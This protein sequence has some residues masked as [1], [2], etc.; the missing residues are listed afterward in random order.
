MCERNFLL[1]LHGQYIE[2]NGSK[3][4]RYPFGGGSQMV[5][6]SRGSVLVARLVCRVVGSKS[7][8]NEDRSRRGVEA[9]KICRGLKPSRG[10]VGE[11]RRGPAWVSS[12]LLGSRS[13]LLGPPQIA[14]CCFK[15]GRKSKTGRTTFC[16][17]R[18]SYRVD[19][20]RSKY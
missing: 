9:C 20:S 2:Q 12:L 18:F 19:D 6:A 15:V 5:F 17:S 10:P 11:V 14:F 16:E 4:S 1:S 3:K 13:K 8:A 7:S